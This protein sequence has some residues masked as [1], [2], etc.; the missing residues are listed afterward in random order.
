MSYD[1]HFLKLAKRVLAGDPVAIR[2]KAKEVQKSLDG[3]A[4]LR[5]WI[6]RLL[7]KSVVGPRPPSKSKN[8]YSSWRAVGKPKAL[9]SKLMRSDFLTM[10]GAGG[11]SVRPTAVPV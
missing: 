3:R 4:Y 2:V 8:K 7:S 9:D 5:A 10:A 1:S 11:L 6:L